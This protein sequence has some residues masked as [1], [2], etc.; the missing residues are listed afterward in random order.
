MS[1]AWKWFA[2]GY[3]WAL[4][5]TLIGLGLCIVYRAHSFGW[6]DGVLT[7]IGGIKNGETRIWGK[8]GAQTHGWMQVYADERQLARTDL[9]VHENVHVV[10]GFLG[11]PLFMLAYVVTFLWFF[12][13]GG[14]RDWKA[15]Y[16]RI[17]F[18]RHAYGVQEA[19][20]RAPAEEQSETWGHR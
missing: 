17:F 11:G 19:Y 8:P 7:C 13:W 6:R 5:A 9:R 10:Q 18:E 1:R 3:L 2:I 16:H 14:F 15:A 20:W 4:P 12:A